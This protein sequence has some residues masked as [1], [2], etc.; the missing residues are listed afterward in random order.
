MQPAC[1]TY[2]QQ[3]KEILYARLDTQCAPYDRITGMLDQLLSLFSKADTHVTDIEN[4][5][6]A[7][8]ECQA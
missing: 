1:R 6:Y 8:Q 5:V 2:N 7:P 4:S 3:N